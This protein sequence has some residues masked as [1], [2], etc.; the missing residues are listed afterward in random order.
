MMNETGMLNKRSFALG[1]VLVSI[2]VLFL[3]I[4]YLENTFLRD[5]NS[6]LASAPEAKFNYFS[7]VQLIASAAI[8]YDV[9][10]K[11]VLF[12]KNAG[13]Q[14]PLASVTKL[15]LVSVADEVLD[16]DTP[17]TITERSLSRE[18]DSGLFENEIWRAQDLM[19]FTLIE[20][21][22]DGA[23]ALSE[24]SEIR[25]RAKYLNAPTNEATI[26]RMNEKAKELSLRQTYFTDASGLDESETM[27]SAYGSARDVAQLILH[28]L[29]ETP[30]LLF[31]TA[32]NGMLLRSTNG[33]VH[34]TNNTNDALGEIPGLI[35]GKTGFTDLAGGNLAIVFDVGLR[36]PIIAVVLNSTQEGRFDDMKKLVDA[37][38]KTIASEN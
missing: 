1:L 24:A 37:S 26:W 11:E 28:I 7:N 38:Q 14:L 16:P 34:Q 13:K 2:L 35:G 23:E 18:G 27:A 12:H 36:R 21:S 19:D 8:V 33:G 30:E 25:I 17:V 4:D 5:P 10:K 22:N 9:E 32:K 3:G 20:S 29:R 31:A 6:Q 15:M